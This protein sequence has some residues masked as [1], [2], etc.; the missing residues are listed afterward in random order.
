VILLDI[1]MPQLTGPQAFAALRQIEPEVRVLFMSG[2]SAE[3]AVEDLLAGGA[4]GFVQKPFRDLD[5][6]VDRLCNLV[7]TGA[8]AG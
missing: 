5:D 8:H 1:H 7:T 4:I 2:G 3:Y 6:V